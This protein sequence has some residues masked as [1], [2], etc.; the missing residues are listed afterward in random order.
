VNLPEIPGLPKVSIDFQLSSK[1]LR[2]AAS[3]KRAELAV[4]LNE[5]KAVLALV[6]RYQSA[7]HAHVAFLTKQ[8]EHLGEFL[9]AEIAYEKRQQATDGV[10]F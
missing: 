6:V 9:D 3:T 4:E 10:D 8:I 2:N 7:I 1:A 5:F